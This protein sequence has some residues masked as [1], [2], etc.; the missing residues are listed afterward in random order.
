MS[1][2][3]DMEDDIELVVP[4]TQSATRV[5][6]LV[7]KY[8]RKYANGELNHVERGKAMTGSEIPAICGENRFETPN[9]TFFKKA[10]N[11][12]TPDSP[13]ML[14]G[15]NTEPIAINKF[16]QRTRAKVF[17]VEFMRHPEYDF[18]GGTFDALA[19][20]PSGEGALVEVKC[21]HTRSI[22]STIPYY[23]M[24]QVQTYL[25]I[26]GL[27]LCMFV[28]YKLPYVTG[29][30]KLCR[31]E[32]LSIISVFKDARYIPD[33]M[34]TLWTFWKRLC[35]FREGV[36]PTANSAATLIQICWKMHHDNRFIRDELK[37]HVAEFKMMRMVHA[38]MS[39]ATSEMMERSQRPKIIDDDM[40][41]RMVLVVIPEN[42]ESTLQRQR[43]F[44]SSTQTRQS[45]PQTLVVCL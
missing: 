14:H 28:Q 36:L 6:E 7:K 5:V 32:N 45:H 19:I 44:V 11:V 24:G 29:K 31:P 26:A 18:L 20:L 38:G 9:S 39:E 42:I 15:R 4:C 17:Y 33:R 2:L 16:K 23:Y 1:T 41:R 10:F 25:D 3:D 8:G 37:E 43:I 22:G 21:P 34:I 35:A 27:D 40:Q 13:A 30:L 12:R